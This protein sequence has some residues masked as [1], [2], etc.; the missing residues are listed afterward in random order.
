MSITNV[1]HILRLVSSE[2]A[3]AWHNG[4]TVPS[5]FRAT[6]LAGEVGEACNAVKKL[7]RHEMGI[8]G[9]TVDTTNLRDELADV[10]ICT[11]LLAAMYGIDLWEAVCDK[12]NATSRK[13]GF[14]HLLNYF[15]P[16]AVA[17]AAGEGAANG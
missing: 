3:K 2:R 16:P 1:L 13:H 8:V 12:F 4:Q 9:G 7:A 17:S 5:T 14:P 15:P 6:E 11:D 10:I